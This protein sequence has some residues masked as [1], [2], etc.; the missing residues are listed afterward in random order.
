MEE[1]INEMLAKVDEMSAWLNRIMTKVNEFNEPEGTLSK[2]IES[3]Q[4][5]KMLL[6]KID[7]TLDIRDRE[8][9]LRLIIIQHLGN[10]ITTEDILDILENKV[11]K[12]R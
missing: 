5:T 11:P 8:L 1:K 9:L 7:R 3:Q 10:N 4:C 6:E 12:A 2:I